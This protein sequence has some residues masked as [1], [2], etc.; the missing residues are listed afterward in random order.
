MGNVVLLSSLDLSIF[1]GV[2][3][4]RRH[5]VCHVAGELAPG[6]F[7]RSRHAFVSCFRRECS[8]VTTPQGRL[9]RQESGGA[10][11]I[12]GM[13]LSRVDLV[14]ICFWGEKC[15]ATQ[16]DFLGCLMTRLRV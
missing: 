16:G 6:Y 4:L 2:R 5:H 8:C 13:I 10:Y 9:V 12:L 15:S 7:D 14:L 1:F 11:A 3:I